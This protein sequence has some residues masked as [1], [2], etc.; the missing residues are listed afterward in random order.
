MD[1]YLRSFHAREAF[2]MEYRICRHDGVVRWVLDS[3]MPRYG[4]DGAFHGFVGG[5]FDIAEQKEAESLLRNLS[6]RLMRAQDEERRRIARELHDHLSQQLALL[7]VDLQQLAVKHA[8][9]ADLTPALQESWR[10]TT[11]ISSDVHAISHRLHPSK[12]EALGLVATANG[13]CRDVSR[14]SLPVH[15]QHADVPSGILPDRALSMFRILEEALSNVVRH[16]GATEARVMLHG[17][18]NQL[19]LRVSDNGRGFVE[20]GR[21]GQQHG[22]GLVSMRERL[23]LLEGTLSITSVPAKGTVVEARIPLVRAQDSRP[24][25]A[26]AAP[27]TQGVTSSRITPGDGSVVR[28]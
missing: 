24:S 15:F 14:Q 4:S 13:H 2:R 7:A 19:I 11:E 5:C 17:T 18:D 8:H 16:S 22:L 23:Q 28:A 25:G 21:P 26:P 20:T 12:M 27:G 3:G 1:H 9:T 6:H 10:R